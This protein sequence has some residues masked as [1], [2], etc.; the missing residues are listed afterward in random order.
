MKEQPNS[1][2]VNSWYARRGIYFDL[3]FIFTNLQRP[4][5]DIKI[6]L[7]MDDEIQLLYEVY[8][9]NFYLLLLFCYSDFSYCLG[10]AYSS[11]FKIVATFLSYNLIFQLFLFQDQDSIMFV[12]FLT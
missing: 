2:Q 8:S 3:I 12:C 4:D 10:S 1:A 11:E 9:E 6:K 5:D 7:E